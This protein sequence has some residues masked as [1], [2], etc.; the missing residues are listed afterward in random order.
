MPCAGRRA[1]VGRAA[2]FEHAAMTAAGAQGPRNASLFDAGAAVQIGLDLQPGRLDEV[3]RSRNPSF[4]GV[5]VEPDV[6]A[7]QHFKQR[8]NGAR[9]KLHGA[10]ANRPLSI[11]DG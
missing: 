3:T 9:T 1:P 4:R 5:V 2:P 11:D 8:I 10:C 7:C 6:E